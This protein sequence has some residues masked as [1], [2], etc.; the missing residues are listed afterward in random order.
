MRI[1]E[2]PEFEEALARALGR[3]AVER[4]LTRALDSEQFDHLWA[5]LLAS[6]E[7]QRLVERIAEAPEVRA[8]V[9]AQGVGLIED[10]GRQLRQ[11][12]RR[13]DDGLERVARAIFRRPR[14]ADS[15]KQAGL[16]TRTL[17][18][19]LDA[20]ILNGIFIVISGVI[21]LAVSL[22]DGGG[23]GLSTPDDRAR[24]A[25]LDHRLV[26]LPALLLVAVRPDARDAIPGDR[27]RVARVSSS[28]A[29]AGRCADWWAWRW[30]SSLSCAGFLAILFSERRRGFQDRIAD[31]DV[32]YVDI[33][34][35]AA[36]WSSA[37]AIASGWLTPHAAKPQ[38]TRL[39]GSAPRSTA[40]TFSA[41]RRAI[42][43]R[44]RVV[45]EP[46]WGS[47][48]H[49]GASNSSGGTCGSPS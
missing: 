8:A 34:P 20:V 36:P 27:H 32:L 49:R 4:A 42:A 21:A 7:A 33:Q 3:P 35:R 43:S 37:P 14:R 1:L 11:V 30:R 12:A 22:I 47:R 5:Q 29:F 31:T 40:S 17:A 45:A 16:V 18:V 10:L 25:R 28:S 2:G 39:G 26:R 19:G 6:D 9:T 44:D 38:A 46:T 41:A 23:G 13:L 24:S 48:T 15:P